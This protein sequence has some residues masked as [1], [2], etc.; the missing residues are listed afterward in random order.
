[1]VM[2]TGITSTPNRFRTGLF[3]HGN[4]AGVSATRGVFPRPSWRDTRS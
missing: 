4:H 3:H 1:M 2:S